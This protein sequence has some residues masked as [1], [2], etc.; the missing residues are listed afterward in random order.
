MRRAFSIACLAFALACDATAAEPAPDTCAPA[1][2]TCAPLDNFGMPTDQSP[3][4]AACF[5]FGT[6]EYGYPYEYRGDAGAC[7]PLWHSYGRRGYWT[8]QLCCFPRDA[9]AD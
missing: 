4:S 6:W 2:G 8:A 3:P 5:D 1:G 9:G 7:P